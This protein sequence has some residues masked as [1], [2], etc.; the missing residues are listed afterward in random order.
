[1]ENKIVTDWNAVAPSA[2]GTLVG[3]K[4]ILNGLENTDYPVNVIKAVLEDY[5]GR[6]AEYLKEKG[7]K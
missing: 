3:L 4:M 5:E 1:M 7:D 2:H 6:I